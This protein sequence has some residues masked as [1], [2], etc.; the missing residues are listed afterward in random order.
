V[1]VPLSGRPLHT[2]Y[3]QL[4]RGFAA[5]PR[6]AR[7]SAA[8]ITRLRLA[9]IALALIGGAHVADA[10]AA[11]RGAPC[12]SAAGETA[13]RAEG[14]VARRIYTLELQSGEVRADRSEVERYEPLLLAMASRE[15]GAI[16]SAVTALVFSGT[17][18]VRLQV[19]AHGSVLADVGG[20][21]VLAPVGGTLRLR[22]RPVGSYLLSVQDD[23]GYVKLEQRFVGAPVLMRAAGAYLPVEGSAPA[24]SAPLPL[25][26]RVSYRGRAYQAY[27]FAARAFPA[28]MLRIALL[29]DVHATSKLSC[30]AVAVAEVGRIG[31]R[32]WQRFQLVGGPVSGF[33]HELTSLTGALVYVR[34]GS[35]LLAGTTPPPAKLRDSGEVRFHGHAFTIV[36]FPARNEGHRVRV[37][38]LCPG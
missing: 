11:S 21:Y 37:Y 7:S 14:V 8:R 34:R 18:I 3:L 35:R 16:R 9:L 15:P 2:G 20:P 26:G 28:G 32:V 25:R 36:S 29:F 27:T 10:R 30:R 12:G 13:A 17:H 22:G 23:S 38:M 33:T 24:P 31:E 5:H 4:M 6:D 19:S 1:R